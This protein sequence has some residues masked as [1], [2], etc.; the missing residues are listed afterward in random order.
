MA[1]WRYWRIYITAN[2]GGSATSIQEIELRATVGGADLTTP[3]T[4]ADQSRYFFDG[5]NGYDNRAFRL[6]DND[7]TDFAFKLWVNNAE[8]GY[9][10]PDWVYFD[11]G[12]PTTVAELAMWPQA[13]SD[14]VNRAPRDFLFQGCNDASSW[15]TEA[16]FS[17]VTGWSVG[18]GKTFAVG[19]GSTDTLI[20][21]GAADL[22]FTG[23]APTLAQTENRV[24]QPGSA[25]IAFT[26]Y[27]P[28]LAQTAG[29]SLT[30]GAASLTFSGY[31]PQIAQ[32]RSF[33]PGAG[34]LLLTGY[35]PTVQQAINLAISPAA[36]T[37]TFTGY[38][39]GLQ[40]TAN[41]VIAPDA[42]V[43]SF[44]GG[45]PAVAQSITITIAPGPATLAFTGQPPT[46]QQ[47]AASPNLQPGAAVLLF[48]GCEPT[49]R[50]GSPAVPAGDYG[51]GGSKRLS[52]R[53]IIKTLAELNALVDVDE[54]P[55]LLEKPAP[56]KTIILPTALV[57]SEDDEDEEALMLLFA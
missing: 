52:R 11:L 24:I 57:L 8:N 12:S 39:P 38:A 28:T 21:P 37:I 2:N 29:Q 54:L 23:S 16:T 22:S 33:T 47:A 18:T 5:P 34:A 51:G 1:A 31:A 35:A 14:L 44:A 4:P 45:V 10:L 56:A 19:S 30:P 50:Q 7:F 49:L 6:V 53:K 55:K 27:A 46:V 15:S 40:R 42:A 26:G 36:A 17:D 3:S 25:A 20:Q 32:P 13:R 9:P 41:Q 43:L 48:S